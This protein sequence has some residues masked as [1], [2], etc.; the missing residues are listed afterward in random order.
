MKG[1]WREQYQQA[2]WM[3]HVDT[4]LLLQM[5][6]EARRLQTLAQEMK[7][8]TV[9]DVA[10]RFTYLLAVA[11]GKTSALDL[12]AAHMPEDEAAKIPDPRDRDI[13]LPERIR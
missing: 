6:T 1:R 2:E 9:Q 7:H 12:T 11:M 5:D 4:S 3:T 8:S 13:Q 10:D